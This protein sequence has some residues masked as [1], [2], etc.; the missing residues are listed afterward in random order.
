MS[1]VL[2]EAGLLGA[3]VA[4]YGHWQDERDPDVAREASRHPVLGRKL[5]VA[6]SMGTMVLLA[7]AAEGCPEH[8]VLIGTPI[9]GYSDA[10]IEALRE[11]PTRLPCLFIQ[12][13]DDFTGGAAAL[14]DLVGDVD[15]HEV[16]GSDHVY[17]DVAQLAN[18]IGSWWKASDG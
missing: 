16:A 14:R 7:A 5:V 3:E 4:R 9:N 1:E 6:K 13:T 11:L 15:F 8:A 17:G 2:A 18:L 12:Q 10:Q